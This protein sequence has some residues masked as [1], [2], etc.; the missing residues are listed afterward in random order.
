MSRMCSDELG[1]CNLTHVVG[2]ATTGQQESVGDVVK[3][4]NFSPELKISLVTGRIF[5][6]W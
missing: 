5:T 4:A 6:T 1:E 3:S 2:Q